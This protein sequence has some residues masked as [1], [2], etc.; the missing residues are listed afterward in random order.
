MEAA[1]SSSTP[2][3]ERSREPLEHGPDQLKSH[4]VRQDSMESLQAER[5][6][7]RLH[8][9]SSSIW[10]NLESKIPRVTQQTKRFLLYIRGPRP[11]VDLTGSSLYTCQ[12]TLHAK[13]STCR[14][15]SMDCYSDDSQTHV[16]SATGASCCASDSS[17]LRETL[18]PAIL[19]RN[20]HR[21]P[22][23]FRACAIIL[24]SRRLLDRL[25]SLFLGCRRRMWA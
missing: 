12:H 2:T 17:S 10:W 3:S 24:D 5:R 20:L 4:H 14:T 16:R 9:W 18:D 19:G 13:F 15:I 23:L 25:Y 6:R 8:R 1:S 21:R 11:V 22:L 7:N